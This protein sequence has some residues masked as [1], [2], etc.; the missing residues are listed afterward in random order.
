MWS[1]DEIVILDITRNIDFE[2]YRKKNFIRVLNNL[3]KNSFVPF[4][5][6]GHITKLK[7]IETLLK[8]GAD[9]IVLNSITYQN[10]KFVSDAVKEFGSSCIVV[11]IDVKLS[12]QNEYE[13]YSKNG[14]EKINKSLEDHIREMQEVGAGE[15]FMQSI[16]KD[17]TLEGFDLDL[18]NKVKN[19]VNVPF[20][21]CSGAGNWMHFF[22]VFKFDIISGAATN[23]I[24]HL[25]EKSINTFKN[26]LKERNIFIR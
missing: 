14:K 1:I 5:V 4:S 16:D 15:I 13:I 12:I 26:L 17:G 7:H 23:N 8:N 24:F 22:E 10:K 18:I 19:F 20:I 21:I 2:D 6:D 11:S 25:T 9:K 3:S